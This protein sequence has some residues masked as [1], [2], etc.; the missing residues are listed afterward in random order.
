MKLLAQITSSQNNEKHSNS[1]RRS[2]KCNLTNNQGNKAVNLQTN[3]T[4]DTKTMTEHNTNQ[5][6]QVV[7]NV[8]KYSGICLT[9]ATVGSTRSAK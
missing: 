4:K 5:S 2:D 7:S 1:S 8:N 3:G 6:I 9:C